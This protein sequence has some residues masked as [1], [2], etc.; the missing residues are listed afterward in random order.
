MVWGLLSPKGICSSLEKM[1]VF[2]HL[3]FQLGSSLCVSQ[4]YKY[5]FFLILFPQHPHAVHVV[6]DNVNLF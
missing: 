2:H 5:V 4:L 6:C 1:Y 3:C